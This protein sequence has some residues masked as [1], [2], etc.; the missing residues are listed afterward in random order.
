[1][2]AIRKAFLPC[3][4]CLLWLSVAGGLWLIVARARAEGIPEP[5]LVLYGSVLSAGQPLTSGQV[6]WRITNQNDVVSIN[7]NISTITS[8]SGNAQA[9]YI[10]FIPLETRTV[11]SQAFPA[12]PNTLGLSLAPTIFSRTAMINGTNSATIVFSSRGTLNTFTL[13]PSDRGII[14]RVDLQVGTGAAQTFAQ[15]LA[16]YN[17]PA[18]TDPNADPLHKGMTYEQ[19]FIAGTDPTNKDSL[20]ELLDIQPQPVGLSITWTSSAG[21]NYT[22]ERSAELGKGFIAVQQHVSAL[23]PA[24]YAASGAM[25]R[26]SL[27][28]PS[29]P[30]KPRI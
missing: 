1:M 5:S 26:G 23:P 10:A 13:G 2:E 21:R 24:N 9:F 19:Q 12:A 15:W 18:N 3:Q 29:F 22:I 11:G 28:L 27:K 4:S 30:G 20:F 16:R 6:S 25:P 14:E 7:A 8:S 17:L